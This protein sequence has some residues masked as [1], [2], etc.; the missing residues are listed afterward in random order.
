MSDKFKNC[1][2][3]E[4]PDYEYDIEYDGELI[5][6]GKSLSAI[7]RSYIEKQSMK[8]SF[9]NGELNV[10]IDSN[11]MTTATIKAVS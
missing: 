1:F 3:D 11:Q 8:K 5:A 2:I 10:D 4:L 9:T 6:R 7:D